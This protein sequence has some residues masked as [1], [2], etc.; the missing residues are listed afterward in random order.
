MKKPLTALALACSLSTLAAGEVVEVTILGTVEFNQITTPPLGDV[1]VDDPA[2]LTF[3]VDS[4]SFVDNAT[5]PTRGYDLDPASFSLVLGSETLGL[6]D[7][8]P[9]GQTPYFVL[10]N[11]DPAVDGFFLS[12]DLDGP[13]GLP[14]EQAGIFDPFRNNVSVTYG[15]GTL[16]S[17][18]ILDAL[19]TYDLTG[20]TVFN[21]TIDDGPFQPLGIL[22]AELSI[23][24]LAIF[25]DGFESGDTSAW[26]A[27]VP[28]ARTTI[29]RHPGPR[30]PSSTSEPDACADAE[31]PRL[32]HQVADTRQGAALLV[33]GQERQLVGHV[34]DE[35]RSFPA[36][37]EEDQA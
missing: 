26:S 21:W 27:A 18:D 5:F 7:P 31:G 8:F 3:L 29:E 24:R 32:V 9:A 2:R 14:I 15:G 17:L 34:V 37:V 36:L 12:T 33:E 19:G 16:G 35:D 20:L 25:A 4:E 22:F 6:Q 30:S 1:S 13:I 23:A 10:R 28:S 11:D